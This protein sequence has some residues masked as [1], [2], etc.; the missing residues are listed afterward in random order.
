[1][2]R[3]RQYA[4]ALA[5]ALAAGCAHMPVREAMQYA[6]AFGDVAAV[7]QELL[8]DYEA[9]VAA[10]DAQTS[11]TT[12]RRS[13]YPL[14]FDPVQAL[15]ADDPDPVMFGYR[16]ALHAIEECNALLIELANG[17]NDT[18]IQRHAKAAARALESIPGAAGP[19]GPAIGAMA[20]EL[21]TLLAHA[22]DR[23][24]VA[25]LL[26]DCRPSIEGILQGFMDATPEFYRVRAGLIGVEIA[27]IEFQQEVVLAELDRIAAE[28]APPSSGSILAL[29]RAELETEIATL[30]AE[31]SP[32]ASPHPLPNGTRPYDQ[33]AQERL[34]HHANMLR[35]LC[36][37]RRARVEGLTEY[38][39]R[40]SAYVRVLDTA[41]TYFACLQRTINSPPKP[42]DA[43]DVRELET[44]A[45]ALR[46]SV[47]AARSASGLPAAT[48]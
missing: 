33:E 40:L 36:A 12:N 39:N 1:M 8:S 37:Q 16:N 20:G 6:D 22:R 27:A 42:A 23:R 46:S 25:E 14:Q 3:S 28:Y 13:T 48:R 35:D 38:H 17:A 47:R 43:P 34:Q 30:R 2:D 31:V 10:L 11:A 32:G 19:G 18:A 5:F 44:Q 7:T 21:L 41:K 4:L 15:N 45:R 9:A 26:N 24:H 29:R